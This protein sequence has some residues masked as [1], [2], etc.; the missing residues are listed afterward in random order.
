MANQKKG[1]TRRTFLKGTGAALAGAVV[2][3]KI[4]EQGIFAPHV[5]HAANEVVLAIQQ[6]AWDGIKAVLPD[7][8]SSTGLTVTFEA[9]PAS[10]TDML[11][12]YSTA[13]AAGWISSGILS[14]GLPMWS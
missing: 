6:F 1:F 7:F 12:K 10:G 14:S 9:G 11:T 8:E 4:A 3:G 5:V 2:G 13:F